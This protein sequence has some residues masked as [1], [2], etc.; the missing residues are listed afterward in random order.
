MSKNLSKKKRETEVLCMTCFER[1][2]TSLKSWVVYKVSLEGQ[3]FSVYMPSNTRR[4]PSCIKR[5]FVFGEVK[6]AL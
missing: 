6:V 3:E 4:C 1:L 5:A 2:K